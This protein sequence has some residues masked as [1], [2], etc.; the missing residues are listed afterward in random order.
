MSFITKVSFVPRDNGEMSVSFENIDYGIGK[1]IMEINSNI[2]EKFKNYQFRE[3]NETGSYFDF[4]TILTIDEFFNFHSNF[5]V[6]SPT[7][8][9]NQLDEFVKSISDNIRYNW[10]V[11]EVF[12]IDF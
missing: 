10:V 8:N 6:L 11:I 4:V 5:L 3:L 1:Y 12:E 7:N 2:K 9:S